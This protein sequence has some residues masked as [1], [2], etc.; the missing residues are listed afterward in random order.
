MSKPLTTDYPAY[1]GQYISQVNEDDLNEAF[2]NQLPKLQELLQ[3][4]NENKADFAYAPGKWT[5]KEL[6][7][8][9]IDA[10]RIFNYRALAFARKETT[11][12]PS[13]DENLY[14]NNSNANARSWKDLSA[15]LLNLRRSTEDLY[16]S[17]SDAML[18][19]KGIANNNSTSVLSLGFI[20]IGHVT[21]HIK[22][23]KEKYL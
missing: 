10:E 14:A 16:K 3:S 17:F 13:F 9:I 6:L 8:H 12:L 2:E 1:F 15:E 18:E 23:V 5:L 21:H 11:S 7:Q 22:V 19:Q 20:T 4:I